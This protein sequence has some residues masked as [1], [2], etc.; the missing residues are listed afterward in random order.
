MAHI[1]LERQQFQPLGCGSEQH[2]SIKA[3]R[4]LVHGPCPTEGAHR[5]AG[6]QT[7]L[8]HALMQAKNTDEVRAELWGSALTCTGSTF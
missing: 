5:P 7:L 6:D 1:L 4:G 8:F 3:W 2:I